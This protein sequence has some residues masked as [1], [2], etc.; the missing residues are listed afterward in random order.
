M[1]PP[2][3]AYSSSV[4]LTWPL[5]SCL[6]C[7]EA[8][9]CFLSLRSL[10]LREC[11]TVCNLLRWAFSPLYNSFS[12]SQVLPIFTVSSFWVLG[13]PCGVPC[14]ASAYPLHAEDIQAVSS[15]GQLWHSCY[16]YSRVGFWRVF[17]LLGVNTVSGFVGWGERYM[18]NYKRLP[19]CLSRNRHP[20]LLPTGLRVSF[21]LLLVYTWCISISSLVILVGASGLSLRTSL[22]PDVN[23]STQQHWA[24]SGPYLAQH[25][26]RRIRNMITESFLRPLASSQVSGSGRHV[27]H[28]PSTCPMALRE[29]AADGSL[30]ARPPPL[31]WALFLVLGNENWLHGTKTRKSI[32]RFRSRVP[33]GATQSSSPH[34]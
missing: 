28:S 31:K 11:H 33:L 4:P 7:P 9:I 22:I 8:P 3:Q 10:S 18:F 15:F 20:P 29:A 34:W 25:H 5:W 14:T 27:S 32:Q 12:S 30:Q 19:K 2:W 13:G 24:T 21:A 1:P 6:L 17:L 23:S 26:L 16:V